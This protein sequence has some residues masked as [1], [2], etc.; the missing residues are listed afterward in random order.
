M[1][2]S[3]NIG[4]RN[5]KSHAEGEQY[6]SDISSRKELKGLEIKISRKT[7]PAFGKIWLYLNVKPSKMCQPKKTLSLKNCQHWC[8][9]PID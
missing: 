2:D 6:C 5:E 3:D 7:T 9:A 1:N 4:L 8:F